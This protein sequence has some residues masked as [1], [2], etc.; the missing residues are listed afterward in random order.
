MQNKKSLLQ[1]LL[2]IY[3]TFFIV[4]A[5]SIAH[6]IVPHFSQG[7]SEGAELG[8]NIVKSWA[9]GTPRMIYTLG[10]INI[11]ENQE[12]IL[13]DSSQNLLVKA[14]IQ[15]LN[16][17]IEQ[18]A[19]NS[20]VMG[21]AFSSIGGSPWFYVACLINPIAY[22]IIII[23]MAYIIYSIRR[24]IREESTLDKRNT[25]ALRSIGFLTIGME[26]L[27]GFLDWKMATKA[28]NLIAASGYTVD[29]SF[30][31]SYT[32]IILGILIIFTAEVFAI[33]QNL[34]EEQKYTI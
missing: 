16:M 10:N 25:W 18:D 33:G 27:Q 3:I 13:A 9:S 15:A 6:S 30:P 29:T 1:R 26:L 23:L 2:V 12:M 11:K 5:V 19:P 21:L 31:I 22:L 32:N 20:S 34:S 4:L 17:Q 24:S 7:F 28:A 8:N 14:R